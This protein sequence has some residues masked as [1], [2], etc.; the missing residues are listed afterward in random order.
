MV[1]KMRPAFSLVEL[2]IVVVI[3][4][5]ITAIAVPRFS[6]ATTNARA[7]H[8][9][10]LAKSLQKILDYCLIEHDPLMNAGNPGVKEPRL[11]E[12][13]NK[14]KGTANLLL[15][16]TS[17]DGKSAGPLGP[18]LREMPFN[19]LVGDN[20]TAWVA[21]NL[22]SPSLAGDGT[23]GWAVKIIQ[24]KDVVVGYLNSAQT[25]LVFP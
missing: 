17:F 25:A 15:D 3:I 23:E 13:L 4:G 16:A 20:A 8:A 19:P 2:V 12:K 21:D 14:A 6:S 7:E 9:S 1:S 10:S 5:I 18:Y 22:G 24:N 11:I